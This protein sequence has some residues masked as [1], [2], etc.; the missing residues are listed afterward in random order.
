MTNVAIVIPISQFSVPVVIFHF[1]LPKAFSFH[2][3]KKNNNNDFKCYEKT[4]IHNRL[5]N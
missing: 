4:E 5:V 1:R 2:K 3:I